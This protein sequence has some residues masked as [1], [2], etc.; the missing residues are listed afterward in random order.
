MKIFNT[1]CKTP[2]QESG[3]LVQHGD[4]P[5]THGRFQADS[6]V[7]NSTTRITQGVRY[8]KGKVGSE[9]KAALDCSLDLK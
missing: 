7:V 3:A 1:C 5:G 9:N 4:S 6:E 8:R 2:A